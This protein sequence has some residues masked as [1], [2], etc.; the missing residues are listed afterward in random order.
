MIRKSAVYN[1]TFLLNF[2]GIKL[3]EILIHRI[4]LIKELIII[5]DITDKHVINR[6]LECIVETLHIL[7]ELKDIRQHLHIIVYIGLASVDIHKTHFLQS[8]IDNKINDGHKVLVLRG[9]EFIET[10]NESENGIIIQLFNFHRNITALRINETSIGF[11]NPCKNLTINGRLI[12]VK[13]YLLNSLVC[14]THSLV[15]FSVIIDSI[16]HN[17]YNRR[18]QY[19]ILCEE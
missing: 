6:G 16:L 4:E 14:L 11:N 5:T 3:I 12:V 15:K 18:T 13:R 7:N 1:L 17:I 19:M 10:V 8:V 2:H 9:L